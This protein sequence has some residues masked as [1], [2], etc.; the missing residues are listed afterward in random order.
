MYRKI[1]KPNLE[2]PG[3]G[4][5]NQTKLCKILEVEQDMS[6]QVEWNMETSNQ[7]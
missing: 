3:K 6:L 4:N 1:T 2:K 5:H 7:Q